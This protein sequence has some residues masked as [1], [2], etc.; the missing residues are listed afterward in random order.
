[1]RLDGGHGYEV[2]AVIGAAFGNT[3]GGSADQVVGL[4]PANAPL[5]IID[6][7]LLGH[8]AAV[9][10]TLQ[11][12]KIQRS[13]GRN[14]IVNHSLGS[15][16]SDACGKGTTPCSPEATRRVHLYGQELIR[17]V[18]G[19]DPADSTSSLENQFLMFASAG[20][21]PTELAYHNSGPC[22]AAA[23][24]NVP[25]TNLEGP[26]TLTE[27]NAL[28]SILGLGPTLLPKLNNIV[29]VEARDF[30]PGGPSSPPFT[31]DYLPP[32][33]IC[34]A[35][36]STL[37]ATVGAIGNNVFTLDLPDAPQ[38]ELVNGTSF[39]SPQAAAA[40]AW[41]WGLAPDLPAD[42]VKQILLR[43]SVPTSALPDGCDAGRE[44]LGRTV[45]DAYNAA[46]ATDNPYFNDPGRSQNLGQA[47]SAPARLWLL[48]VASSDKAT[49]TVI[50]DVPD[51]KFT[52]ADL[53]KFLKEFKERAGQTD[54]SRYDLNGNSSTGEPYTRTDAI[55]SS[56]FDL[57]GDL[58]WGTAQQPTAQQ[59]IEGQVVAFDED[60]PTDL[61]IL[62][63]YAYSPL[64]TGNEYERT[65]LLLPYLEDFNHV[66]LR[67]S[68]L[69]VVAGP[70]GQTGQSVHFDVLQS[71]REHTFVSNCGLER[72]T[73]SNKKFFSQDVTAAAQTVGVEPVFMRPSM[74]NRIPDETP[75]AV[76]CS[77]FVA[78]V[79]STGR[80][81]INAALRHQSTSPTDSDDEYQMRVYLGVPDFA[82]EPAG[83]F[84]PPAGRLATQ[85]IQHGKVH[86]PE[87][88]PTASYAFEVD[89][90]FSELFHLADVGLTVP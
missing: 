31:R 82:A 2:V 17:L 59:T 76:S 41:I 24:L 87:L 40:A 78:T 26:N 46:L 88:D 11:E 56:R 4:F 28:G 16:S 9:Q 55:Y 3:G 45:I 53:W 77:S 14:V 79:P 72:G 86:A 60:L 25:V 39:A 48:D 32:V 81:W 74:S 35:S 89:Q 63:Y 19:D 7:E 61:S 70:K 75:N 10:Q 38:A 33:P 44:A 27:I 23:G 67:L 58:V 84:A 13:N 21:N 20:N 43:T 42:Q 36:Y 50:E 18:A 37:G 34:L 83:A 52:Q 6:L 66:D 85:T 54:Y 69:N 68:T 15:A 1:V 12:V 47:E 5:R 71:F 90:N 64:Y 22:A 51:G 49:G 65:L 57:D 30:A 80:W 8:D 29:A 73:D 62:I